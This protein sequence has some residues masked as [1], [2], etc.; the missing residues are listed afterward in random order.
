MRVGTK[1][2]LARL[3][4]TLDPDTLVSE[5]SIAERQF[6]EIAHGI[7]S[8]AD[9]FILDEPTAALNAADVEVLNR[10]IR[11]LREAG[12]AIVYISHRMD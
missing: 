12:K 9:V 7:D 4:L 3:G 1:D 11:S 6:V 10:H 5:L 2:A 8:D